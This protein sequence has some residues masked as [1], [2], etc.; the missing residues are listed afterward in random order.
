MQKQLSTFYCQSDG[1]APQDVI[2]SRRN[3]APGGALRHRGKAAGRLRRFPD[4]G[5]FSRSYARW[6]SANSLPPRRPRVLI[7]GGG[8]AALQAALALYDLAAD[9]LEGELCFPHSDFV[10]RPLA[11]GEPFRAASVLRY[12]IGALAGQDRAFFR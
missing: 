1:G 7:A 4:G 3:H 12:D 6:V 9:R 11:V 8:V 10:Y 5:A 2:S